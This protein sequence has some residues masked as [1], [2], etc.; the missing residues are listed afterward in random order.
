VE[1]LVRTAYF[2]K[3]PFKSSAHY[4]DCHEIVFI[5][6]GEV[7][8]IV[9]GTKHVAK[10]NDIVLFNRFD[11]H[12]LNVL[13]KEYERFVLR[14]DPF[15]SRLEKRSL[16]LLSNRP[17]GFNNVFSAKDDFQRFFGVFSSLAKED[18]EKSADFEEMQIL[19][20]NELL[21]LLFR[22]IPKEL[23]FFDEE[24]FQLALKLQH[25]FETDYQRHYDLLALAKEFS[26]SISSLCHRF[27]KT[28]GFSVMDYLLSC[29]I[30][31]AKKL[32]AKTNLPVGEIVEK[33]GFTDSSNFSRTFKK[34]TG[35]S[36]TN[37]REKYKN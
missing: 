1:N 24:N 21:L 25:R 14:I 2:S 6:K 34:L 12:S 5:V 15:C 20:V 29:R 23:Y 32:L 17:E 36:P 18:R 8:I 27:K 19:L 7:E 13:S 28:T 22:Q 33:C 31:A 4:H 30:A 37:F 11:N 10:D 26:V 16:A 9:N 35:I 3:E